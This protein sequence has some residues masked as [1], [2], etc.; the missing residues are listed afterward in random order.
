LLDLKQ[1][2]KQQCSK[3]LF[4]KTKKKLKIKLN[5]HCNLYYILQGLTMLKC[6]CQTCI[7]GSAHDNTVDPKVL[8][9]REKH[10]QAV[11]NFNVQE[12]NREVLIIRTNLTLSTTCVSSNGTSTSPNGTSTSS[13]G[14]SASSA[15]PTSPTSFV[16]PTGM[17]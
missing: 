5:I 2:H 14:T 12:D 3:K 17:S 10:I 16:S 4:L 15:S 13:T 7:N 9:N 11:R 6:T 8:E 1:H